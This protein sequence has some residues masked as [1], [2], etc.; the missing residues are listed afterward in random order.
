MF[1]P[2]TGSYS[3]TGSSL[4]LLYLVSCRLHSLPLSL[5][6]F[7][8]FSLSLSSSSFSS[9]LCRLWLLFLPSFPAR[10]YGVPSPEC[11]P[12]PSAASKPKRRVRAHR[13]NWQNE[14]GKWKKIFRACVKVSLAKAARATRTAARSDTLDWRASEKSARQQTRESTNGEEEEKRSGALLPP[15][16]LLPSPFS[17]RVLG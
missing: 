7:L 3:M 5:S 14:N 10:W 2:Y 17:R 11:R 15:F 1:F 13:Q 8:F 12:G 16:S 4:L 9:L 6:L